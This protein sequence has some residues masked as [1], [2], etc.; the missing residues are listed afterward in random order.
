[1]LRSGQIDDLNTSISNGPFDNDPMSVIVVIKTVGQKTNPRAKAE[2]RM[3]VW[4][5][6]TFRR[7]QSLILG[8]SDDKKKLHDA[9]GF[10]LPAIYVG[11]HIWTLYLGVPKNT[12]ACNS[13]LSWPPSPLPGSELTLTNCFE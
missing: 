2:A 10:A 13:L 5:N 9:P 4:L 11:D 12:M 7:F 8:N 6:L 3:A 1:M